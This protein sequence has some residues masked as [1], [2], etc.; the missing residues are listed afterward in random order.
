MQGVD[1]RRSLRV[2]GKHRGEGRNWQGMVVE[3]SQEAMD[4]SCF[5]Y[6]DP[7]PELGAAVEAPRVA[8]ATSILSR[9]Q[10]S[11]PNMPRPADVQITY[12]FLVPQIRTSCRLT[13]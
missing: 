7:S 4:S 11:L 12:P 2:Q 1:T 9:P 10:Q 13:Y 5:W 6:A 3:Q 8:R